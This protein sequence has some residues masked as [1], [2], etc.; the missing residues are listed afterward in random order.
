M[1]EKPLAQV[2]DILTSMDNGSKID[3]SR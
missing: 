2:T 1:Y 3:M